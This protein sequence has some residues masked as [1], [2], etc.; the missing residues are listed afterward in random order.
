MVLA[1]SAVG[2][3]VVDPVA[4]RSF[5]CQ[6]KSTNSQN[7]I[8]QL[9][10]GFEGVFQHL[11]RHCVPCGRDGLVGDPLPEHGG[12]ELFSLPGTNAQ[13]RLVLRGS[14]D[15]AGDFFKVADLEKA[16]N[17]ARTMAHEDIF[18]GGRQE[19]LLPLRV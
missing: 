3:H 16:K 17:K 4:L 6:H 14:Y 5:H 9:P 15:A 7:C 12:R 8:F 10:Y 19:V 2:R 11:G 18:C 1:A 13:V